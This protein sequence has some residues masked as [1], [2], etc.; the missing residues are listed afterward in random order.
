[1]K[2]SS[3]RNVLTL[4]LL[5]TDIRYREQNEILDWL[6]SSSYNGEYNDNLE[7]RVLGTG[8][9]FLKS[10]EF[11]AWINGDTVTLFCPR[12]AGSWEDND[13]D[14]CDRA[15]TISSKQQGIMRRFCLLKL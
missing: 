3:T 7:K 11:D 8:Q 9:W 2:T 13:S 1:M 10:S 15:F 4:S 14:G 5:L 6:A 12:D